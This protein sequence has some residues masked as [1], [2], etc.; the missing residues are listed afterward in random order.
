MNVKELVSKMTLE[1][2]AGLCSGSDFWH[3]KGV[4]RLGIPSVMVCDG[5][6]GLRKQDYEADHLGVNVSIKA[7]CFPAACAL[8]CSFDRELIYK[9]GQAL[10][11]ACQA[12]DISVILGPG[13]NIK[14]SP[15]CG[16]NFEYFSED[17][18]LS[19]QMAANHI[20]GVQSQ[21]VGSSLKHFAV[22][23][24]ENRRMSI[25]VSV[26]ERT[27]REIYLASFETAVKEAKPWTVMCSYN[28]LNGTYTCEHPWL[29]TDVLRNE[30]G[31]DG[32]VVS[33]W[34][35]VDER[36]DCLKA[37][38]ELEMPASGGYTDNLIVKAVNDGSLDEKVLDK[39]V[40]RIL[41]VVYRHIENRNE[42]AVWDKE[43]DA[44]LACDIEKE[45]IVL[46]KN[47]D[48][49]L[50]LSKSEKIAFIGEFA[51]NPRFQGGGSSHINV[52]ATVSAL[53]AV[54]GIY[55][56]TYSKGYNSSDD[57]I[58]EAMITEAVIAAKNADK[59]VIFAGL[60]D[61][62]ESEG[63]DR[64]HMKMPE[65]QNRLIAEVCK[66]QPDTVVVLHNGSPVEMPWINDVKGI[67]EVYLGG[68]SVGGAEVDILFGNANPCGKLGETFPKKLSDNPSYL[69]FPGEG[70]N[71]TY[72]EG[73]FVGYRYY[74]KKEME[75][76]FPFGYGLSYTQFEY[77][78]LT[79]SN[80]KICDTDRLTV[81]VNVKNIGKVAGKEIVQLY[82]SDKESRV[83]RPV[84]ELRGFEKIHLEP[85]EEK[86]V[87]FIL[88]K[89]AF[90]YYNTDI[91]DWH[92]ESGEFEI[93]IGKS[94]RDIVMSETVF[95]ESTVK[96]P[97]YYTLNTTFGDLLEDEEAREYTETYTQIYLDK[98]SGNEEGNEMG[99]STKHMI[100]AMLKDNP[101]RVMACMSN[102]R[103]TYDE[104][105][106]LIEKL[107]NR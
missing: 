23:N 35:A 17:P 44:Q 83:I 25:D 100:E 41:E 74:D 72:T 81:T 32:F 75:V 33:D 16:R 84:R 76:L 65:N 86:T 45:C 42:N 43:K 87:T 56:V 57:S 37:G 46:L 6:H 12:E 19:S 9:M 82:V 14:R 26:D 78:G 91:S 99:E 62:Y 58:D 1:E 13:A 71:T 53:D 93:Q 106:E 66:V 69:T 67:L 28:R 105:K 89:R 20:K 104:V 24:Q 88:D 51:E 52:S 103:I 3:T 54:K 31:F 47:E 49:I 64:E 29:L 48:N 80:D 18:Y 2:K 21:N 40:E 27:L 38:L 96:L 61:S 15:V 68:Q 36:V 94:S 79:L 39:A 5:P 34:G 102:G 10:G 8:A 90:A 77:S 7:V 95:V 85:N 63:F 73:I 59:A 50:P 11:N 70:D 4:E 98:M 92:V 107:N 30:W 101:M 55:D 22:N 97:R 60:P